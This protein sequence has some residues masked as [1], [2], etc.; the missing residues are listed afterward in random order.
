MCEVSSRA[1]KEN[2]LTFKP[3][4]DTSPR[5][6]KIPRFKPQNCPPLFPAVLLHTIKLHETMGLPQTLMHRCFLIAD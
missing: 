5:K 1:Q 3:Y 6:K 2:T 4:L